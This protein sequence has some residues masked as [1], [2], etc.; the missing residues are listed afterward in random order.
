MPTYVTPT[1]TEAIDMSQYSRL[2]A[3][4]VGRT[5]LRESGVWSLVD[6]PSQARISAAERCYRG[7]YTYNLTD[8]EYN[9]IPAQYGGPGGF[10][11]TFGE[12]F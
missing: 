10:A 8:Q 3:H 5:L 6:T 11:D 2:T 7:G 12:N 1:R 4:Y 9:E